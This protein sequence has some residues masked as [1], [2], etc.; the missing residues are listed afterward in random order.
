MLP[1]IN[2][3]LHA[4]KKPVLM[5]G[6]E[7]WKI[8]KSNENKIDV[9]QSRCLRRIFK[10]HWRESITNK[11]VLKMAEIEKPQGGRA[12]EKMEIHHY[13]IMRKELHKDCRTALTWAAEGRRKRGR[14][15]TTWRRTA[16]REREKAGCK[17]WS[18]VQM[19][20]T[21]RDGG[22]I[23]FSCLMCHMARRR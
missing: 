12:K 5:Y 17:N 16:E 21:D 6:C 23:V 8:N 18:E 13:H 14:P 19:A 11:E 10:I 22:E 20:A 3:M 1:F 7:T 2:E 9:F 4:S 15:R